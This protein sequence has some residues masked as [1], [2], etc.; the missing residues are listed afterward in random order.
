MLASALTHLECSKCAAQLDAD[1]VQHLCHCGGPLLPRYDLGRAAQTLTLESVGKRSDDLLRWAELLPL[2]RPADVVTLGEHETPL[3]TLERTGAAMGIAHLAVKD[4]SSL[5][6]GSFKARGAAIGVSRAREL[7]V[8]DVAL[9]TNGNAGSAWAAYGA[10]AG[11]RVRVTLSRDAPAIHRRECEA[12]GA[13]VH[14]VEGTISD[15]GRFNAAL[16]KQH[17][18]FDASSLKEPYRVEGKKT[19]GFEIAR[20]YGWQLPDVIVYPTGGGVGL[21]GIHKA[22]TELRALGLVGPD[23]PRFVA[24]Q[25]SGC[26]PIVQ[27]WRARADSAHE[28]PKPSTLAYGINVPKAIADFLVLKILYETNGS[29]VSVDDSSIPPMIGQIG[30]EEGLVLC[31]EGAATLVAVKQLRAGGWIGAAERVLAINTG[32]GLK[33]L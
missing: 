30:G 28:W 24:V 11:M 25:S 21:I 6:T 12:A 1:V 13:E 32:S 5:P 15:A 33:Y 7:G 4:E 16:V 17:G 27:A 18:C 14:L 2:R 20:A 8:S 9:P 3:V 19:M 23:V 26:A 31:P 22:F 29:A 10:R